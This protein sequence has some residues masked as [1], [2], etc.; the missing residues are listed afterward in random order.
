M[1]EVEVSKGIIMYI[2]LF[3]MQVQAFF[4]YCV[5]MELHHLL[6]CFRIVLCDI[7]CCPFLMGPDFTCVFVILSFSQP[8][9]LSSPHQYEI[10]AKNLTFLYWELL[11]SLFLYSSLTC[12]VIFLFSI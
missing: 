7:L 3:S 1:R 11:L 5:V 6:L 2:S 12:H 8:H 9:P 4:F 10:Y